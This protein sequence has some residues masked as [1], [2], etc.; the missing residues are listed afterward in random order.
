MQLHEVESPSTPCLTGPSTATRPDWAFQTSTKEDP[1]PA[2]VYSIRGTLSSI[3]VHDLR[4]KTHH[5]YWIPLV[6]SPTSSNMATAAA[7]QLVPLLRPF[8]AALNNG[9]LEN[10]ANLTNGTDFSDLTGAVQQTTGFPTD[11]TSLFKFIYSF[12]ALRDWLRLIVIGGVLEM[13]RRL[14]FHY[15]DAF[16]DSF[17]ITADFESDDLTF[18]WI[19]HWLASLPQWR[20]VR[21]FSVS[22]RLGNEDDEDVIHDDQD[23][24][25]DDLSARNN[26]KVAY[27]PSYSMS[28][29]F[30]HKYRWI[31][32]SRTKEES[33][34]YSDKSTLRITILSRDRSILDSMILEAR[35][36]Y[37][38]TQTD[39]IGIYVNEGFSSDWRYVASRAKRP[40]KSIIL[41]AG[42]KELILD[43]AKDF[44]RSKQWYADRG[45][46]FRRGYLLYGA[47]GSGKT[48][49]IHSLAGELGLDIYIISLSKTGLDDTSLN[50]LI[51]ALPERCIALMEDIDAAFTHGIT[52]E[53]AGT[54]LEDPRRKRDTHDSDESD[55]EEERT[56]HGRKRAEAVPGGKDTRITLSGLLN[57]L[58]GI[59]AQEGRLLFATTN[60]YSALDP[61]LTRPGRMDLHVEFRLASRYQARE[62]FRRF[63]LPNDAFL[64]DDEKS[65]KI[66]EKSEKIDE[67]SEGSVHDSGYATPTKPATGD[68]IDLSVGPSS[69]SSPTSSASSPPSP[70]RSSISHDEPPNHVGVTHG[71]RAPSL[72]RKQIDALAKRFANAIPE[73]DFSMASLQGYLMTYKIRPVQAVEDIERWVHDKLEER[74][75]K[76]AR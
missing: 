36:A 52:R 24:L 2:L 71:S 58:D 18:T 25:E 75:G 41:D 7:M 34:W 30:W 72:P 57:A 47:P 27:F 55:S 64:E 13:C 42:V 15:Y 53:T 43:D 3:R 9:T 39:T 44:L 74:D 40:I 16:V 19:M 35:R 29:R 12:G 21:H 66:D 49:I 70:T 67:K 31:T 11:I 60:R 14:Y 1:V 33:R 62:M 37:M 73:R 20:K 45:I 28:Y 4:S 68:L 5:P 32:V 56:K 46:P 65:E 26:R 51:C 59:S 10:L 69:S 63:Y 61:A 17:F 22:T 48:S 38:A 23:D 6:P 54:E 50:T 76:H 8:L